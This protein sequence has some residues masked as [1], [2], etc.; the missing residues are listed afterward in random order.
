MAPLLCAKKFQ[1]PII[2]ISYQ[3]CVF[4]PGPLTLHQ[5]FAGSFAAVYCSA[6][7]FSPSLWH[8]KHGKGRS[9][10]DPLAGRTELFYFIFFPPTNVFFQ[11][12]WVVVTR[13]YHYKAICLYDE[14]EQKTSTQTHLILVE[15]TCHLWVILIALLYRFLICASTPQLGTGEPEA[16]VRNRLAF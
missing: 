8:W 10:G 1:L 11:C 16:R 3:S 5:T 7:P 2:I 15:V 12:W 13:L 4:F 14:S 9:V 6:V